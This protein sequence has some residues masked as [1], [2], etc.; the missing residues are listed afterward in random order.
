MFFPFFISKKYIY[1]KKNSRFISFISGFSI[2]G[3]A[4][5]VA[6]LIIALSILKGFQETITNKLIDFDSHIEISSFSSSLPPYDNF[7]PWLKNNLSPYYKSIYPFASK[8]AII[9][10]KSFKEGVSIKGIRPEDSWLGVKRDLIKGNFNLSDTLGYPSIVIGK[11]LAD[12]LL[13]KTGDIVTLFALKKDQIPSPDN[14]PNIQKF[15]ISGIF[16]SG[17]SIYDDLNAYVNITSAQNLFNLGNNITGYDIKLKDVNKID[18]LT[19]YLSNNLKF[20]YAARSIYDIHRNIFTWVE[21]QKKPV[22]IILG[23]IIIVAVFNIIGTLLMIV[24]EKT[25]AIG[26]LKALGASNKQIVSI[27]LLQGAYFAILGIIIGNILAFTLDYIQYNF[28]VI[29]IPSSV[30]FMS[31][32]P[33]HISLFNFIIVSALTFLLSI[34]ASIIP[35]MIAAKVQPVTALRFN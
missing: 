25:N 18:S 33:V 34:L 15:I 17:M 32:V 28:K 20:P 27:F 29:S 19:N 31:S 3:I 1:S 16:E 13:V 6:T 22:P 26:I 12:K 4:L 14:L 9:S 2:F 30:Y 10:S 23:L 21:L 35:S 11:K 5:G 8:L 7:M 24:L